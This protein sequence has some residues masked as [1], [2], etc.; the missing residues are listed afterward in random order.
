M[1]KQSYSSIDGLLNLIV[2]SV[3]WLDLDGSDQTA[4]L[5]R[6]KGCQWRVDD[7]EIE[8]KYSIAFEDAVRKYLDGIFQDQYLLRLQ[9]FGSKLYDARVIDEQEA[10]V[11]RLLKAD[12]AGL[13]TGERVVYRYWSGRVVGQA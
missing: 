13:Y 1:E 10:D 3:G 11:D 4:W 9:Y 8:G 7:E 2:D 6:F 12:Q 5:V